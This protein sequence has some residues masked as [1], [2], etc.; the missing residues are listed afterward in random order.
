MD[1]KKIFITSQI[2]D[3]GINLLSKKG[4][5]IDIFKGKKQIKSE[6][7]IKRAKKASA[8]I[9]LLSDK[10]DKE[11]IDHLSE[12]KIIAN[13]AVGFNNI[14]VEYAKQKGIVV[15]N[16]PEVLTE[17]TADLTLALIL[18]CSRRIY[19]GIELVKKRKFKGWAPKLLLGKELNNKTVGIIGMGRIGSA[20]A[21]RVRAFGCNVIYF[22]NKRNLI[23]EDI[24][25]AKKVSLN[26]LM[27][28]SDIISIH[29]PLNNKTRNLINKEKL[30]L[31]KNDAILINT[32]R[33][34]VI[35][36]EY[37][38]TLLKNKRIF[39]AGF[40]VYQNE[41]QINPELLKLEN[42]IALPHIGSATYEARNKMSELVAK[43]V[44]AVLSGKRA[45]TPVN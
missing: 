16:T 5:L 43:N 44:I 19:E 29:I 36:E 10:V 8:L 15:T 39:S 3:I 11:I 9:T 27:K 18:A 6:E 33:G 4:F 14:D 35:D 24:T 25:S 30:D 34:E 32:A 23:A 41:P 20:V 28:K 7:L 2:P 26:E 37:L 22:S 12:T 21:K 42:V 40:D 31:M 13:Y 17:S 1:K 38:I 45:L